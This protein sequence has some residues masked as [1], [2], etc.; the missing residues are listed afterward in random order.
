MAMEVGHGDFPWPDSSP[1]RSGKAMDLPTVGYNQRVSDL[2]VATGHVFGEE[3][4]Q[5]QK[6]EVLVEV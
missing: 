1:H 4:Q 3:L 2:S 6:M 5:T